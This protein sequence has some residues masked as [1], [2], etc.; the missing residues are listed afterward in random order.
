MADL[1]DDNPY[2]ESARQAV[3]RLR[4]IMSR[5]PLDDDTFDQEV[6]AEGILQELADIRASIP[7]LRDY[8]RP[9]SFDGS[10]KTVDRTPLLDNQE[11]DLMAIADA[12]QALG[13]D[14][15]AV[16]DEKMETVTQGALRVYWTCK[17]LVKDPANAHLKP[18]LEKMRAAYERDTGEPEPPKPEG[19]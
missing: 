19:N 15:Q 8:R 13:E 18:M 12:V 2:A 3:E 6:D 17:E 1:A 11:F 14:L 16:I 10:A 4:R 7:F 5:L 9:Q